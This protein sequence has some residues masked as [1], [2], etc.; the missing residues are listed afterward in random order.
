MLI[1][2]NTVATLVYSI[3]IDSAEGEVIENSQNEPKDLLFG[4]DRMISGF[5][6]NLIGKESGT[7][8]SFDITPSEAFGEIREEMVINVPKTAF[9]VNGELRE[10][11]IFLGNTISMMDNNGRP[12]K[13]KVVE[14]NDEHVRMDFNHPL[15]GEK[16]F[17]YGKILNVRDIKPEDLE[18]QGGCGCGS[19]GSCGC[20][21]ESAGSSCG[22]STEK[23][24]ADASSGGCGCG[25]GSCG[26]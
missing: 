17:V 13:G 26:C 22:C 15:A 5:E 21:T 25:G 16:L 24:T 18:P 10:D 14:I 4:F 19:G 20:S 8:F 3:H 1:N 9:M 11:L 23:E 12:L 6:S 7:E 2:K